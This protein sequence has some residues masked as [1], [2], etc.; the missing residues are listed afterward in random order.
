MLGFT[1]PAPAHL[2]LGYP[3]ELI[4]LVKTLSE[5]V[6]ARSCAESTLLKVSRTALESGCNFVE[7]KFPSLQRFTEGL[8][9]FRIDVTMMIPHKFRDN[10]TLRS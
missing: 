2:F 7:R 6:D 3:E 4:S 5:C 8:P 10:P 9:K 1:V